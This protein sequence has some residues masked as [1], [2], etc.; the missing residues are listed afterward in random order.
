MN[1]PATPASPGQS[2]QSPDPADDP[3]PQGYHRLADIMS[4]D[5]GF[6]I[7]RRFDKMNILTLLS[8]QAEIF[9]LERNFY[10]Q[11]RQD[12]NS[13]ILKRENLSRDFVALRNSELDEDFTT[14]EQFRLLTEIREKLHVYSEYDTAPDFN[15]RADCI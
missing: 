13:K 10:W 7:F 3:K 14:G 15:V 12:N 8:L 9:Q 1:G 6:A 11:S 4:K 5:R 2:P